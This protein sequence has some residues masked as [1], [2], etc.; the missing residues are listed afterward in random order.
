MPKQ[1]APKVWVRE[2]FANG[3]ERCEVRW[4]P[5]VEGI[6]SPVDNWLQVRDVNLKIDPVTGEAVFSFT[7]RKPGGRVRRSA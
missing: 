4:P 2:V 1:T 7:R 6:D 5:G 3:D